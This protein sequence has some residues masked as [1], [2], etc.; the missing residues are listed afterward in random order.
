MLVKTGLRPCG[1]ETE[2][3]AKVDRGRRVAKAAGGGSG[4]MLGRPAAVLR[5]EGAAM[6]A[7]SVLL[8]WAGGASWWLFALLLLAPDVSML[9][10]VAGPRVGA[11][12]YNA[13]HSYPLPAVLGGFGLLFG[14]PL[15]V[16]VALVWFAHIGMDRTIGY[17]LKYPTG[18]GDTHMGRV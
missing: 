12:A 8:Y 2:V 15:A 13:F 4:F 9:G 5:A 18:F 17:G 10:Y 6:F 7:G 16:A 3:E 14:V 11:A 1:E